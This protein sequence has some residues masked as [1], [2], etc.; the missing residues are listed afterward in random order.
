[1]AKP[2]EIQRKYFERYYDINENIYEIT[3]ISLERNEVILS[4]V[5]DGTHISCKLEDFDFD[6][7]I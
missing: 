2:I 3:S 6:D 5:N 7:S 4:N 1:M